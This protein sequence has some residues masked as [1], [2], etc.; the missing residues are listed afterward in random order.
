M[1]VD[2]S[3]N[4][5]SIGGIG[6]SEHELTDYGSQWEGRE[7]RKVSG[8]SLE[9]PS[10]LNSLHQ[11]TAI[12]AQEI[13]DAE[14]KS[15][16]T[17]IRE[18]YGKVA[19][20][21]ELEKRVQWALEK[22]RSN[23]K[24]R[25]PEPSSLDQDFPTLDTH[26]SSPEM[27]PTYSFS[28]IDFSKGFVKGLPRGIKDSGTGFLSIAKEVIF[29]PIDTGRQIGDSLVLI[30][31]LVLSGEWETLSEAL[32]PEIHKLVTEWETI[33][34]EERG[35]MAGY[36]FGKYGADILIPGVLAK[37]GAKGIKGVKGL[38][39]EY[40]ALQM[41]ERTLLRESVVGLENSAKVTEVIKDTSALEK[42]GMV[43]D[44]LNSVKN[45]SLFSGEATAGSL[46][47]QIIASEVSGGG[48]AVLKEAGIAEVRVGGTTQTQIVKNEQ[49]TTVAVKGC[50]NLTRGEVK[51]FENNLKHIFRE[52]PGHLADTPINRQLLIDTAS[53]PQNY[54]G[55]DR[56]GNE[57]YSKTLENGTQTWVEVRNGLIRNAG[58]NKVPDV[59]EGL[60]K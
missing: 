44:E 56:F 48:Q 8:D 11:G 9:I 38:N 16:E 47:G 18:G 60:S 22:H 24:G 3:D 2:S 33:P 6:Y 15:F 43:S 23:Q 10:A 32:V 19:S 59:F 54:L 4:N 36:A 46:E 13:K 25:N 35:E 28:S 29:H 12:N 40:K 14:E 21:E 53:N 50:E 49:V 7:V 31:D 55:K 30:K 52:S 37:L 42:A 5:L 20:G 17:K 39:V 27:K 57:W 41:T 51:F 34:S 45:A 58:L 1:E 26:H